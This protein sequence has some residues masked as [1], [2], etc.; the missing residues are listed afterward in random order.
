MDQSDDIY[1]P[2][3]VKDV[4]D[5]CSERYIAFSYFCSLGFTERWRKQCVGAL[6][7]PNGELP[8]G[9]KIVGW[10]DQYY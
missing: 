3:F 7:V 8:E 9:Y 4:F 5:R 10:Q 1:D 6:P 2:R